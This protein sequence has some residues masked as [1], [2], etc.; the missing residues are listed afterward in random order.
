M[1]V[2]V[3]NSFIDCSGNLA[4]LMRAAPGL[5]RVVDDR[6]MVEKASRR[7]FSLKTAKARLI[8]TAPESLRR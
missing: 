8:T 4:K 6:E 2:I 3:R 7:D 5:A 1:S